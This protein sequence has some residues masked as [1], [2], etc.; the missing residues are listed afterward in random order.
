[1]C[2]TY[3][4]QEHQYKMG[5][6]VKDISELDS[7]DFTETKCIKTTVRK[8]NDGFKFIVEGDDINQ[9]THEEMLQYLQDNF[10]EWNKP[11]I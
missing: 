9:F 2:L 4:I 7:Y 6:S 3:T 8:S 5:Y 10:S 1:M 11:L